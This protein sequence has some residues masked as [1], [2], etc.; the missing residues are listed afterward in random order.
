MIRRT[1]RTHRQPAPVRYRRGPLV[2]A[3]KS[4]LTTAATMG[5]WT[6]HETTVI[7]GYRGRRAIWATLGVT[8]QVHGRDVGEI[9]CQVGTMG[10][11]G[12]NATIT[13]M[14]Q[15]VADKY[16]AHTAGGETWTIVTAQPIAPGAGDQW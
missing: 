6:R 1:R 3:L 15:I 7:V 12:G 13:R 10:F 2:A 4:I 8:A 5:G 14:A 16:L 11:Y 9:N